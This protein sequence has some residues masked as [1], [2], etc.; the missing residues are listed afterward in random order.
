MRI[1][2]VAALFVILVFARCTDRGKNGQPLDTTTSGTIKIAV[3]ESLKPLVEAE[4]DTFEGIYQAA[5]IEAYYMSEADAI[6]ALLKDSVVMAVTTRKLL[7]A[8]VKVLEASALVPTQLPLAKDGVALILNK[9]NNDSLIQFNQLK[10]LIEGKLTNWNQIN[11]KTKSSPIEVVFD[12]PQSG[13]VRFLNDSV[14]HIEKL[15]PNFFAVNTNKDVVDYVSKKSN[16]IGLIGVSWIS[17][18]DDST[19]NSFLKDIRVAGVERGGEFFK[20][21]QAYIA[22]HQYPLRRNVYAVSREARSGLATGFITF[23]TSDRGQRIVLKLGLVPVTMPIRLVQVNTEPFKQD[24][25]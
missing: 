4:I 19:A 11:S 2:H 9:A 13:M 15:P 25:N 12:N 1:I 22:T 24:E 23:M 21:Y 20:P 16:A 5:H 8:E 10:S 14:Q 3:D 18:D 17:D 7:D 6:D